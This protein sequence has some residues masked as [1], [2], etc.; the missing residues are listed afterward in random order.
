MHMSR[1]DFSQ[2]SVKKLIMAQ[3]LPLTLA[4]TVQL[5]YN[6]VDRIYIG[7]LENVGDLA[8]TGLG[9][10]FPV[11]VLIAAFTN[12]YGS[13]GAT[14]F[15]L[16]RG[17]GDQE[18]AEGLLGNV[19]TLLLGTSLILFT[20]C[21]ALRR[22]I[23]FLFGASE[24]S[25]LYADQYL[26]IYLLG[27]AFS[28]LTTGLN[29]FINA[30]GFPR[31]GMLTTVLGA[32]INV[33][34]DP[35]FIFGFDMGVRGAALAT[36]ISQAI[37]AAWVL[38]FLLSKKAIVPLR[39]HQLG[40]SPARL[41]KIVSLGFP[42]FVMQGTNSLVQIICNNQLQTYGGDLYVG[43]MTVL[44]SVREMVSLPISGLTHGSQPI[45]GFNYG[46]NKNERVKEGIRFTAILGVGYLMAAWITVMLIPRTLMGIFSE[47]AA[48]ITQGA[49][50]LNIYFFGFVFMAFQFSGQTTFQALGKAKHAI[51][52]SLLRKV[53]IVVPLTLLL[54]AMGFGV[55][56]VFLAEPISNLIGG[57]AAFTTMWITVYR[58][59]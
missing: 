14:L 28:M 9:I 56:G 12:L 18:E 20:F 32:A 31:I 42:G 22:H 46:A 17:R 1:T 54:P 21:Y 41:K 15:A 23:L 27:T 38:R 52:F 24:Q 33:V 50:M 58:K 34:L 5:L 59:L 53:I 40:I 7:H 3:A 11:I 2:G 48:T 35:V 51:F 37:S 44:S 13:G 45:L 10:T 39:K 30:Q 57:L 43:I 49:K 19:F 8:L 25:Y 36:V 4:Q 47:D 16:A 6:I 55:E 26:S 29:S